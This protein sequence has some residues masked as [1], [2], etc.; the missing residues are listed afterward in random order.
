MAAVKEGL[1]DGT[2]DAIATDH[3]PH[4]SIE[5]DVEF[6]YAAC[7]MIGLETALGLSL[8]LV[9]DGVLTMP[10]L[11]EKMSLHP[12]R[13]L[14]IP[15]GTLKEGADGDVTVIDPDVFWKVRVDSFLSLSR[16]SPFHGGP[17]REKPS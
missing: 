15:R 12:A 8:K 9:R 10:Q 17:S 7:G 3:A 16:N 5:K 4:S 14:R 6:E 1:A 11:V 13:I 2:I